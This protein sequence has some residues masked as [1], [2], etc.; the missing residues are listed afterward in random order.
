LAPVAA[1][2]SKNKSK[3]KATDSDGAVRKQP[4]AAD[5]LKHYRHH[6]RESSRRNRMEQLNWIERKGIRKEKIRD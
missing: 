1:T 5:A 4:H 3:N 2:G 6:R